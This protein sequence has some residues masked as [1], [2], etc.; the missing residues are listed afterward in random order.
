MCLTL[1]ERRP[2][3]RET[4][5]RYRKATKKEKKS[6]LDEFIKASE[7]GTSENPKY[8]NRHYA[9][10]L[11]RNY[12]RIVS[13]IDSDGKPIQYEAKLAVIPRKRKKKYA[14]IVP[15]LK[16]YWKIADYISS[17]RLKVFILD[18]LPEI[19][20]R[21][22]YARK[23][24]KNEQR[25][26]MSISPSSIDRHLCAYKNKHR[27]KGV[28]HTKAGS[29]LK[30]KIPIRHHGDWPS[31]PGFLE[32][33]L[34]AHDGGNS[35]GDFNQT[36]T[37]HDIETTWTHLYALQNKAHRWIKES[38][39]KARNELPFDICGIDS[40][41]GA[42]FI[43]YAMFNYCK[44]NHIEFTRTRPG[45]KNDN[46]YVEQ[47]NWSVVRKF[48]GYDRFDSE[49]SWQLL[50]QFYKVVNLYTNHFQPT[51]K[52]IEKI[53]IGS[54]TR[55][56][57]DTPKTPYVRVLECPEISEEAKERLK[58]NHVDLS[59]VILHNEIEKIQTKLFKMAR[60]RRDK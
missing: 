42:E 44:D 8:Y 20:K 16:W 57:Y 50:K 11:L 17:R 26:L 32:I 3:I 60:Q 37:L 25:L 53:R 15:I 43:N 35:S 30:H 51:R 5:V 1:R 39:K 47:K 46:C 54:R 38:L 9:A 31:L 29:L 48:T 36:L 33:D 19:I 6:V 59:P 34:V 2:L 52:L 55:K 21:N 40:D 4:A 10:C 7:H 41:C 58:K 22:E 24:T 27:I 18:T 23:I 56:N 28:S 45:R 49:K 12:D 14:R 13:T